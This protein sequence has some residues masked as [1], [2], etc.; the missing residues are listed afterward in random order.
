MKGEQI[1]LKPAEGKNSNSLGT[2]GETKRPGEGPL[3][4]E[5]MFQDLAEK[6]P[7]GVFLVKDRKFIYVNQKFA[8]IHGYTVDEIVNKKGAKDLVHPE[9]LPGLKKYVMNGASDKPAPGLIIIRGITKTDQIVYLECHDCHVMN[10]E[11][12]PVMIGIVVDVTERKKAEEELKNYRDHLQ[13]LVEERTSQLAEVNEELRRDVEKRK[14]A[15][16]A[17]E[18]RSRDLEDMNATLRVLLKQRE[19]DRREFEEKTSSN[20]KELVLRYIGMLRETGLE[21]NQSLLIDI[22]ERN[23]NDFLSP[24]CMKITSFDFTPREME[25][26][27]LTKE[28]KTAKQMAQFL[29][30]SVDAISR[31]RYH[32][33]K[34]LGLN[35]RRHNLRSHLL[36]LS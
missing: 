14:Q 20:V 19:D 27:L 12:Y 28:G 29:N 23:L 1:F 2:I 10:S 9:D 31:H 36:S 18:I 30:V 35:K 13:E 34:K 3:A 22:I 5:K 32:I 26:I 21:P 16:M 25:V 11:K 4:R 33:R 8:E 24:F 15:E 7:V 17:L 6:S